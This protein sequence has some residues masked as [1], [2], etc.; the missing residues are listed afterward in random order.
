M[1]LKALSIYLGV[2]MHS[3]RHP[4]TGLHLISIQAPE[5]EFFFKKG[6]ANVCWVVKFTSPEKEKG[7]KLILSPEGGRVQVFVLFYLWV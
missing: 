1:S 4:A 6:A 3:V 5:L 7:K 2:S